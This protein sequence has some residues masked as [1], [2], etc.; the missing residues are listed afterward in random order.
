MRGFL[1]SLDELHGVVAPASV[2][3]VGCGEGLLTD[4]LAERF[5]Q[6]RVVGLDLDDPGLRAEWALRRR[7]NLQY[8]TG[9]VEALPYPDGDFEL[10]SAI[11]VL[12]HV[13]DPAAALAEMTR[14]ASRNVLVS[15]P[16]EPLWR[17]LNLARGAY[18]RDLGNTPGHIHHLSRRALARLVSQH[19]P[20]EEVRTPLPWTMVL[21]RVDG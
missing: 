15:V 19:A 17:A 1:A 18:L 13:A 3:D 6:A 11:E 10:V 14:V 2:L 4:R 5:D 9:D 20:I 8:R 7:P 16:R 12:E 21:A